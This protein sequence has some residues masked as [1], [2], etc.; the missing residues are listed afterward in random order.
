MSTAQL[1]PITTSPAPSC[2][3]PCSSAATH[4]LV[5]SDGI[6]VAYFCL[7]CGK[8]DALTHLMLVEAGLP[9]SEA[10]S[11][12]DRQPRPLTPAEIDAIN[13]AR[14]DIRIGRIDRQAAATIAEQWRSYT[15]LPA[16]VCDCV[17]PPR[18]RDDLMEPDFPLRRPELDAVLAFGAGRLALGRL[19]E[20]LVELEWPAQQAVELSELLADLSRAGR[21][22]HARRGV[23]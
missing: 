18:R 17:R 14:A 22:R 15:P 4:E 19:A 5:T 23:R 1:R 13:A 3:G 12:E 10:T 2:S 11:P 6:V 20:R 9:A 21:R 7:D 8:D 16:S